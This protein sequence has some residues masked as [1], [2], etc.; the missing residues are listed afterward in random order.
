MPFTLSFIGCSPIFNKKWG[1]TRRVEKRKE[2]YEPVMVKLHLKPVRPGTWLRRGH[3]AAG[4]DV[5]DCGMRLGGQRSDCLF[6]GFGGEGGCI[7]I[8]CGFQLEIQTNPL[9]DGVRTYWA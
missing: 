3:G 9:F 7:M 8:G 5:R 6:D 2:N 1:R 4:F